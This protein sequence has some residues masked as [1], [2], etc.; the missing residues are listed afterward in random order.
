MFVQITKML[1]NTAD[2]SSKIRWYETAG[3]GVFWKFS[4][5]AGHTDTALRFASC[6]FV[7][8]LH[9]WVLDLEQLLRDLVDNLLTSSTEPAFPAILSNM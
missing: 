4:P 1:L 9:H 7:I 6:S 2:Y 3:H 5:P 8:I